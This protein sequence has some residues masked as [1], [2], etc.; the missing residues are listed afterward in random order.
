MSQLTHS[1]HYI[2]TCMLTCAAKRRKNTQNRWSGKC[3]GNA[4]A[5]RRAAEVLAGLK[6]VEKNKEKAAA[7][8]GRKTA[9]TSLAE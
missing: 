2:N 9:V 3:R 8:R 4:P 1:C 5:V 6:G 7:L